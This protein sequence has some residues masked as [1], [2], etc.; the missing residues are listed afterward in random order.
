MMTRS[1]LAALA[2]VLIAC[3]ACKGVGL[4]QFDSKADPP[5]AGLSSL[6]T[7][8]KEDE[9]EAKWWKGMYGK[10]HG[11]GNPEEKKDPNCTFWGSCKPAGNSLGW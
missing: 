5:P 11:W 10:E 9:E 3:G 4:S 7:I 1:T 2:L 8:S 6:D